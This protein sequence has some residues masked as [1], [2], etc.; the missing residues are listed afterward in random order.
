M[1]WN[2]VMI[3]SFAH[4]VEAELAC[5][6]LESEGIRARVAGANTVSI[7]PYY[8]AVLGGVKVLVDESDAKRAMEILREDRTADAEDAEE[9]AE[10]KP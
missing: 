5:S 10:E 7:Q 4:P 1:K 2:P 3:G 9:E 8:S 6:K